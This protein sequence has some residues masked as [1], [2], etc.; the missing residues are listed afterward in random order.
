MRKIS[1]SVIAAI[2]VMAIATPGLSGQDWRSV[3]QM[4]Q[5]TGADDLLRVTIQYGAG[6]LELM[7]GAEGLLYRAMMRYDADAF[8]PEMTYRAGSLHLGLDD[9]RVRGR[10]VKSGELKVALGP[11]VPLDLRLEFGAA[12]ANV[13][14]GGLRVRRFHLATGASETM[15][16]IPTSNPVICELVDLN[17]GAAKFQAMGLGNLNTPRLDFAGGVGDV[18]LD[19]SGDWRSDMDA[20]VRMGL[21]SLTLRVPRTLGLQVQKAGLLVGFD[22]EGLIK[23]GDVYYSENWEQAAH[24]LT[25]DIEAAF[26]S[27]RVAWIGA[28]QN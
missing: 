21:G 9:V 2:A 13:D 18:T 5:A 14:L 19:F 12:R 25:V 8:E 3:T 1:P 22:S 27:I 26:G 6:T 15:L 16:R 20:N 4:R 11:T 7:P 24:K 17:V 23:R 28:E 10:N